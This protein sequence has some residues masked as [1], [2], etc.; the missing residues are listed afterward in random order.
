MN[1]IE[2]VNYLAEAEDMLSPGISAC[3]GCLAELSLR[4]ALKS[5]G[6]KTIITIPPGCM[7]ITNTICSKRI[8]L[9]YSDR[10]SSFFLISP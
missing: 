4:C 6:R 3:Q 9:Q 1:A 7:Q 10:G 2:T 8:L 5:L